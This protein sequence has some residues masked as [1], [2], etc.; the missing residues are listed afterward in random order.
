MNGV[1]V[2][3]EHLHE[4]AFTAA[5]AEQGQE[6][7]P[8]QYQRF[9]AGRTDRQGL[10][11]FLG[12][13]A[14]IDSLLAGKTQ[15]YLDLAATELVAVDGVVEL[16]AGIEADQ[17]AAAVVTSSTAAETQVVLTALG[18]DQS[19]RAVVSADS[20]THGKPDP[21][22]YLLGALLLGADPLRSLAIEDS[23]A[24]VAAARQAGLACLAVTQ[25]HRP[26]QLR[27]ADWIADRLPAWNEIKEWWPTRQ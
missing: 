27:A 22:G 5:L 25:T 9:F 13:G 26:D 7:S 20:V 10:I 8:V 1:L 16:L 17:V 12:S 21:E 24:G 18:L 23:P 4:A 6:L 2:D 11:E 15:A 3:D 14:D 19:F